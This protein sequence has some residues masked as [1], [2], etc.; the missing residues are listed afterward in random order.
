MSVSDHLK[1]I[2]HAKICEVSELHLLSTETAS[3]VELVLTTTSF[4]MMEW[5]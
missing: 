3:Q 2:L 4:H 1:I 5:P